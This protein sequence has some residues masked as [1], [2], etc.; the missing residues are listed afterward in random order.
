MVP[1]HLQPK[2]TGKAAADTKGVKVARK[3][4]RGRVSQ[5]GDAVCSTRM[6]DRGNA[7]AAQTPTPEAGVQSE[8][9]QKARV[10]DLGYTTYQRYYHLFREGELV[11]LVH[12]TPGLSVEQD[13]YDHENWCVLAAKN[14]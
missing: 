6:K 11:D 1:W 10:S 3:Q 12:R 13:F 8:G 4:R 5:E 7:T 14:M 9:G 2:Y